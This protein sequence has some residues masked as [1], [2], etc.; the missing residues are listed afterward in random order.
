VNDFV[1]D[2]FMHK[3]GSVPLLAEIF[4]GGCVS[5]FSRF[6]SVLESRSSFMYH[7]REQQVDT[8]TSL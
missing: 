5:T 6:L 3:D 4:A 8:K 7:C 2:K 1:R